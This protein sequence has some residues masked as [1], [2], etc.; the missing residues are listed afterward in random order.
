MQACD[1]PLLLLDHPDRK[2]LRVS[3]SAFVGPALQLGQGFRIALARLLGATS[4]GAGGG[5]DGR[6]AGD[7]DRSWLVEGLAH[8][9]Q[10][11]LIVAGQLEA[12]HGRHDELLALHGLTAD[13]VLRTTFDP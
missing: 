9:D 1:A 13:L 6:R 10:L 8:L 4:T 2:A 7:G 12:T 5:H 3:A 11:L